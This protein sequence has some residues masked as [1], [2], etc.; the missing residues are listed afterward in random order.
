MK[1]WMLSNNIII[2]GFLIGAVGGY[3]YYHFV[4]CV[5]GTCMISSKPLNSVLYFGFIGGL[6]SGIFKKRSNGNTK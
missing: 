1:N 3:C 4:G 2:L 5:N 6:F